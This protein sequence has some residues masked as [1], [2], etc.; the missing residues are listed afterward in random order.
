MSC[1]IGKKLDISLKKLGKKF[2][3][4]EKMLSGNIRNGLSQVAQWVKDLPVMQ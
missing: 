2:A 1:L 4:R 3:L